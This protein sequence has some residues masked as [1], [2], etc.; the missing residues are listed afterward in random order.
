[1]LQAGFFDLDDRYKKLNERDPLIHL[2]EWIDW[3]YF[4]PTL[5]KVREKERKSNAGRKGFDGVLMF[6]SCLEN[7]STFRGG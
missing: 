3:E 6:R 7:I 4:R 5:S 2:N 1:M